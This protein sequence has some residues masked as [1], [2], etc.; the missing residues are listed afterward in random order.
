MVRL[1][2]GQQKKQ[3]SEWSDSLIGSAGSN[4][5]RAS[6]EQRE[7]GPGRR[8]RKTDGRKTAHD[9]LTQYCQSAKGGYYE[10]GTG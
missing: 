5:K 4:S 3:V 9:A 8:N 6:H 10:L 2:V 1:T 7:N